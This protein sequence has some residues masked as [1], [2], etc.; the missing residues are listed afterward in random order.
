MSPDRFGNRTPLLSNSIA[1]SV[2]EGKFLFEKIDVVINA[3]Q[4]SQY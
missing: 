2:V 3:P 1:I 4:Q